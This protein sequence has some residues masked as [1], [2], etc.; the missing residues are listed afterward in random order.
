M[1]PLKPVVGTTGGQE[2]VMTPESPYLKPKRL[3]DVI[4]A[5]QFLG[6]YGDYK[7]SVKDWDAKLATPPRSVDGPASWGTVFDDHPEFFRRNEDGLI[8]LVWRRA[9]ARTRE[10]ERPALE[11]ET[12]AKLV[13]TAIRLHSSAV[14]AQRDA[15]RAEETR[16]LQEV[17]DRRW[18]I[19]LAVS[20]ATAVLAFVGVVL[21][22]WLKASGIG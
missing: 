16:L 7:R 4:A 14:D 20:V 12:V 8:S 19:Q 5:L 1:R 6:Q 11:P 2:T 17:Q 3:E 18:R 13:E 22:G 21:A 10:G 15:K 9:I